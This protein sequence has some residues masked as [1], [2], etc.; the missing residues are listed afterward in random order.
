MPRITRLF[1]V[2]MLLLC[3][4]ACGGVDSPSQLTTEDFNDALDPLGQ[5]SKSF[6]VGKTGEM[7]LTLQ[8][9]NPRPVVGFISLAIGTPSGTTCSPLLGYI[10]SQA[11]I[12]QQYAF[13]Q[14]VKGS[15]CL[16]VADAN[17][18]LTSR[19]TFSVRLAHP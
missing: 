2:S 13:P 12:G 17:A 3:L 7:Q 6:S 16:L 18:A 5:V 14:I 19:A 15:Y 4:S 11:A 9:L 1:S 10:V 8:S